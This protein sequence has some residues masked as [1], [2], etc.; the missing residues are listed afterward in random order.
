MRL[1]RVRLVSYF[2]RCLAVFDEARGTFEDPCTADFRLAGGPVTV[3]FAG[4]ALLPGLTR[5]LGHLKASPLKDRSPADVSAP[6]VAA[7]PAATLDVAAW[8]T[9]STRRA[10]PD[11]PFGPRPGGGRGDREK[12]E[13]GIWH[14]Q[15]RRMRAAF[16]PSSRSLS[17]L[18]T[19]TGRALFWTNDHERLPYFEVSAPLRALFQ[20][21]LSRSGFQLVHAGAVGTEHGGVLVVGPAG[22]GK[23]TVS[24]ACLDGGLLYAGDDYVIVDGGEQPV[25]HTVYCSGKLDTDSLERLPSFGPLVSNPHRLGEEKALIFLD[26]HF[27]ERLVEGFTL[28]AIILPRLGQ[29]TD[30]RLVPASPVEVLAA[31]APSTVLQLRGSR[32]EAFE[33][34][35]RISRRVRGYTLQ[36]GSD[37][38]QIP[39]VIRGLLEPAAGQ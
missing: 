2:E 30:T 38:R 25:V 29:Y 35:A 16:E 18:D 13:H 15:G 34:L 24:M 6:D 17:M 39:S 8:D 20:W 3:R 12:V 7:P 31:W 26:D 19:E 28:R 27:P 32:A 5:A 36:L 14:V 1:G 9:A 11:P 23:S 37:L 10:P 21:W 4:P 22:A 33:R